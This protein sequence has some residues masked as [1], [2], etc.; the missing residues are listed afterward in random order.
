MRR[1]GYNRSDGNISAHAFGMLKVHRIEC[2]QGFL[3]DTSHDQERDSEERQ[4]C[5]GGICGHV[6]RAVAQR[7]G[8][9]GLLAMLPHS[10]F[11]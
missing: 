11:T 3:L 7:L 9:P 10:H 5:V 8:T 6:E 2:R 1:K 4:H